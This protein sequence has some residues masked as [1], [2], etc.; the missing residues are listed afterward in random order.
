MSWLLDT[1]VVSELVKQ[2]PRASVVGWLNSCEESSIH[3]SVIT[4]GELEKGI[5]R[6]V[7]GTR[8]AKLTAWVRR[9]LVDRFSGRVLTIDTAVAMRWGALVGASEARGVPLPVI[10]S[11]IAATALVHDLTVVTRNTEDFDRCGVRCF[12]P[13]EDA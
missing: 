1:C 8:R 2:K 10:D 7:D 3:L 12:N 11:L 13:W 9:D 5:A 4:L 6:L